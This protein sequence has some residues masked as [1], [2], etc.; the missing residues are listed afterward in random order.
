MSRISRIERLQRGQEP[1]LS[2][3]SLEHT[4]QK[5][6][7]HGI[8]AAPLFLPMHTQHNESF[9]TA[10]PPTAPPPFS[11][12]T[13]SVS[14]SSLNSDTLHGVPGTLPLSASWGPRSCLSA[15]NAAARFIPE[16]DGIGPR[17]SGADKFGSW[18]GPISRIPCWCGCDCCCCSSSPPCLGVRVA[19][20]NPQVAPQQP[21]PMNP[22]RSLKVR[23][24]RVPPPSTPSIWSVKKV[25]MVVGSLCLC[26][27]RV[28]QYNAEL[29]H[30]MYR[31]SHAK[32]E[33]EALNWRRE[34]R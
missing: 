7:P 16:P 25:R 24:L 29:T 11:S 23:L 34:V 19:E 15:A 18:P 13:S 5:V 17:H 21:M 3:N 28:L 1:R 22:S 32:R 33:R 4:L 2:H 8:K 27:Q 31:A 9:P 20:R 12:S 10:P 30:I 14:S 26:P 6:W